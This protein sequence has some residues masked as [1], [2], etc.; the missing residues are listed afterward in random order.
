VSGELTLSTAAAALNNVTAL[1][2]S[3]SITANTA[4][5]DQV[6]SLVVSSDFDAGAVNFNNLQSLTVKSDGEFTTTGTIGPTAV[7]DPPGITV[8]IAAGGSVSV[9][10]INRLKTSAIAGALTADGFT[11]HESSSILSAAAGGTINGIT[12]PAET[13]GVTL[14]PDTVTITDGYTVPR[15]EILAIETGSSLI[16]PTTK[17]LTFEPFSSAS[18]DGVIIAQGSTTGGTIVID[19]VAGYTTTPDGVAGGNFRPALAALVEDTAK[20]TNSVNLDAF[21]VD[22]PAKPYLGIGSVTI[23]GTSA[24]SL[25]SPTLNANTTLDL[26][27]NT[28]TITGT[29]AI[30][31]ASATVAVSSVN[32]QV[33]D[34]SYAASNAKLVI[35]NVA[36]AA[37]TKLSNNGLINATNVPNFSIGLT[38]SRS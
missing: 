35:L 21:Y 19:G 31:V 2:V 7:T 17:A 37:D 14:A 18:G 32:I 10:S 5:Y 4:T 3:G 25:D 6:T 15:N 30:D 9:A 34:T 20:L 26:A 27:G 33:T 1:E 38:T 11:L 16:I 24:T 36:P 29:N 13:T 23:S 28:V 8:E 12:F 22:G